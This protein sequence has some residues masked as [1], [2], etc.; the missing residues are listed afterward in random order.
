MNVAELI[1]KLSELGAEMEVVLDGCDCEGSGG[2]KIDVN[3]E[4]VVLIRIDYG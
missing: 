4:G 2:G 1:K 3:D